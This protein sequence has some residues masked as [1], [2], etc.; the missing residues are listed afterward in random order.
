LA[1]ALKC[2]KK[3]TLKRLSVLDQ[4]SHSTKQGFH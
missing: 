4:A 2:S 3:T 1:N